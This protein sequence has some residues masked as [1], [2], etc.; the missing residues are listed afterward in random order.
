MASIHDRRIKQLEQMIR[1]LKKE[2]IGVWL[3][4]IYP[5]IQAI[6]THAGNLSYLLEGTIA[7]MSK[8]YTALAKEEAGEE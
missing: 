5:H 7:W 4:E 1:D 6:Q 3:D 2:D 8:D